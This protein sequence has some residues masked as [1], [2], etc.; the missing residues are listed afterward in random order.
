[1][2]EK[3]IRIQNNQVIGKTEAK[4]KVVAPN[5]GKI[6]YLKNILRQKG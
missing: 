3:H 6:H 5:S 2:M 1:M 4:E